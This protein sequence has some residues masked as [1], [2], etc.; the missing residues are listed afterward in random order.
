MNSFSYLYGMSGPLDVSEFKEILLNGALDKRWRII[1][2]YVGELN[3]LPHGVATLLFGPEEIRVDQDNERFQVSVGV[4]HL[5]EYKQVRQVWDGNKK[6]VR[7]GVYGWR[8]VLRGLVKGHKLSL[9]SVEKYLGRHEADDV[10][11]EFAGV[12]CHGPVVQP[13]QKLH[14]GGHRR[15]A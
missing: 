11:M 4:P 7:I 5:P 13:V 3:G 6:E 12:G 8:H 10:L 2:S 1:Y 14:V 9:E 15:V